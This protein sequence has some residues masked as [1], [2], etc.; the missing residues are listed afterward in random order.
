MSQNVTISRILLAMFD[1]DQPEVQDG[2]AATNRKAECRALVPLAATTHW[3]PKIPLVNAD[4]SFVTQLIATAEHEP[5]T[6]ELRRGSLA[7]A[8][9]AYGPH[10]SERRSVARRTRQ[11]I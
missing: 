3:A 10:L 4:P 1:I 11:I 9:S 6:R 7:D 8:Q 2:E 5:Q